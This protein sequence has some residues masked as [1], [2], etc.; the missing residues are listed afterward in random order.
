MFSIASQG[1]ILRP[2]QLGG[3][4]TLSERPVLRVSG[5]GRI[6]LR[7]VTKSSVQAVCD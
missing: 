4:A 6:Y 5:S 2:T 1:L 7:A 3:A